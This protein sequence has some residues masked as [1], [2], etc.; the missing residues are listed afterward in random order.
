MNQQEIILKIQDALKECSLNSKIAYDKVGIDLKMGKGFGVMKQ[1][2]CHLV[3]GEDK[4]SELSINKLFNITPPIGIVVKNKLKEK[5]TSLAN[6]NGVSPDRMKVRFYPID[7][8]FRPAVQLYH[9]THFL[10]KTSIETII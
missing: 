7:E 9:D 3:N 6:K 4:I 5:L 2:D 10:S 1:L 8:S